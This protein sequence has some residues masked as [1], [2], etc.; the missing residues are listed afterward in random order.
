MNVVA[1]QG[2]PRR[3]GNTEIVLDAVLAGLIEAAPAHVT[4]VRAADKKISGCAEC[5]TCQTAKDV[6]GCAIQDDMREVY[7][8]LL[9]ADLV[10]LASP[11]FC[12]AV[13]AQ[14]KAVLDRLY[15][16]FKFDETPP[17]CLLAGKKMALVVTSG[18]LR[19]HG[20]ALCEA[21]YDSLVAL[22]QAPDGGRLMCHLMKPPSQTRND[23]ALLARAKEFGKSLA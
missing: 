16:C 18:G 9:A 11:V 20:A 5:F 4:V 13:T 3:G 2:S 1:I 23:A 19:E 15:A 8:A 14:L 7:A 22:S 12:W 21:M 10:I 6:P 17:R